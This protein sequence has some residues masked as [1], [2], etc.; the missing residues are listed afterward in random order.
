MAE[1]KKGKNG[2]IELFRFICSVWVAYY[3][4][5]SPIISDKFNGVNISVDLFFMISGY[6]FLASIEKYREKPILQG[7]RFIGWDRNKR[8]I[9]PLIIAATSILLCNITVELDFGGFN[10]P[11]S[12]LWFF[13]AQ[14]LYLT[15]FYL[16]YKVIKKRLVFNILCGVIICIFM[17]LFRLEISALDIPFRG[18]AMLA[19]GILISQIPKIKIGAKDEKVARRRGLTVNIIGFAISVIVA[20]YL[21]YLPEF[22][23]W[24]LH[25][26]CLVVCPILLYF[27][28]AIPVHSK[29]LNL[30]GEF[31]IFI[32]L[33]QCPILLHYYFISRDPMPQFIL[34][35]ICALA[36]FGINRLVNR[37][38]RRIKA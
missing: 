13:V 32:Y 6:F 8:F 11:L 34:L 25:L 26:F 4:G 7:I 36:L 5:F 28:T 38:K 24:K 1:A 9:V 16:L 30:L 23:I 31:S 37:R 20:T 21:A 29:F 35:C 2:I 15:L 10:W 27:A 12:F 14:F 33:A 22:T 18:P 17:S 19:V 3:H